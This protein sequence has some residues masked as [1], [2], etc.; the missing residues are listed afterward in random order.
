MPAGEMTTLL[1]PQEEQWV[2]PVEL[3]LHPP[4]T[5]VIDQTAPYY[6]TEVSDSFIQQTF[7]VYLPYTGTKP[8]SWSSPSYTQ[9]QPLRL[10]PGA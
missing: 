4:G 10:V 9:S 1:V 3:S 8:S 5:R 7:M 2:L 6:G